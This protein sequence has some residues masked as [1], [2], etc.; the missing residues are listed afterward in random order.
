MLKQFFL[1]IIIFHSFI[2]LHAE[3]ESKTSIGTSFG[4]AFPNGSFAHFSGQSNK[5]GYANNGIFFK[6]DIAYKLT[7]EVK[8]VGSYLKGNN[9]LL[10]DKIIQNISSELSKALPSNTLYNYSFEHYKWRNILIGPEV[11]INPQDDYQFYMHLLM[12]QMKFTSPKIAVDY[13]YN[14]IFFESISYPV[15]TSA[16]S[17]MFGFGLDIKLKDAFQLRLSFDYLESK[18]SL[19]EMGELFAN[20]NKVNSV[21]MQRT[22]P[23]SLINTGIGIIYTINK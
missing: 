1:F 23:V 6:F 14:N 7:K 12:G 18:F 19:D 15:T 5:E 9:Y 2:F 16:F 11:I 4:S 21:I 13:H 10:E 3:N 17:Y 8:L 20:G 22:Q